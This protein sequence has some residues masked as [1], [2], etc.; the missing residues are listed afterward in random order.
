MTWRDL[1]LCFV[2]EDFDINYVHSIENKKALGELKLSPVDKVIIDLQAKGKKIR[3]L[4]KALAVVHLQAAQ[5]VSR[6]E[7]E[8]FKKSPGD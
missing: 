8:F 1:V 6:I 3:D 2:K 4:L 7:T 5:D